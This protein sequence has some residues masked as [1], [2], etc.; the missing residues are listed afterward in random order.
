VSY[1]ACKAALRHSIN[2]CR[3][4]ELTFLKGQSCKRGSSLKV[5]NLENINYVEMVCDHLKEHSRKT[6]Q[7][8]SRCMSGYR[9]HRIAFPWVSMHF[10]LL[11]RKGLPKSFNLMFL[12]CFY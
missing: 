3:V 12:K 8:L 11:R 7:I 9:R 1:A 2:I 10:H 6:K 4:N 5:Y